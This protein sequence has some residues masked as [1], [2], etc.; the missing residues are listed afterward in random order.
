MPKTHK[1]TRKQFP[2]RPV[3]RLPLYAGDADPATI[4]SWIE[5]ESDEAKA[6]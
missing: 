6:P 3:E 1:K 4:V 5:D 2:L